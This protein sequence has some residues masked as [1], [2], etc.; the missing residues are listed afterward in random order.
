M[1]FI[2]SSHYL[3]PHSVEDNAAAR[4]ERDDN[5]SGLED[6]AVHSPGDGGLA[7][8]E[9]GRLSI[10]SSSVARNEATL[11]GGA[12]DSSQSVVNLASSRFEGNGVAVGGTGGV[13]SWNCNS[14]CNATTIMG[15]R[16][17]GNYATGALFLSCL[18]I[19]FSIIFLFFFR[20]CY[21][22][23]GGSGCRCCLAGRNQR[24]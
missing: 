10:T 22:I 12:I 17:I 9:N 18:S 7:R 20:R 6:N 11:K 16:F 14:S 15:C 8:V 21:C 1:H 4:F 24:H 13:L 19:P 2:S 3:I 23:R 5:P